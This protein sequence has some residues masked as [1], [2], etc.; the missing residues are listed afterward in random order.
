MKAYLTVSLIFIPRQGHGSMRNLA[1][2]I[3]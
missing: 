2:I 1:R 3:R